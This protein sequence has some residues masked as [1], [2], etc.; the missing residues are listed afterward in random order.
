M[1]KEKPAKLTEYTPP[2]PRFA[3]CP[4][5]QVLCLKGKG[6]ALVSACLGYEHM[7]S[8]LPGES[9]TETVP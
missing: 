2:Q 6:G 7:C 4:Q 9:P 8:P 5:C 1:A 3:P